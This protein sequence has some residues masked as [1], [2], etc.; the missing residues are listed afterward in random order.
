MLRSEVR[1]SYEIKTGQNRPFFGPNILTV[2]LN[3]LVSVREIGR[4]ED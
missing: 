2:I 3:L 4:Y 1:E